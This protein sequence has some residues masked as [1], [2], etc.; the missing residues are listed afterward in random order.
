MK[1]K[2]KKKNPIFA[3]CKTTDFLFHIRGNSPSV[4]DR[5]PLRLTN[6][7]FPKTYGMLRR[8]ND[9]ILQYNN[10]RWIE[11]NYDISLRLLSKKLV[12]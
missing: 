9:R 5:F 10:R 7:R 3:C 2:L 4:R 8:E 6:L 11:I 1:P 12:I